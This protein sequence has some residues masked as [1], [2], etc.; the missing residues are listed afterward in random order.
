MIEIKE[1]RKTLNCLLYFPGQDFISI[2]F[3]VDL[4]RVSDY[5]GLLLHVFQPLNYFPQS[6]TSTLLSHAAAAA[7]VMCS[8]LACVSL[9]VLDRR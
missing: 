7:A 4:V 9:V 8:G 1:N 3:C 6:Q 2:K 5:Y